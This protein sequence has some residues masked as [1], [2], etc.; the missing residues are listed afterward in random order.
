MLSLEHKKTQ[1]FPQKSIAGDDVLDEGGK[2]ISLYNTS[3]KKTRIFFFIVNQP[4][5]Q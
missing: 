1:T 4:I 2:K 3:F 5:S